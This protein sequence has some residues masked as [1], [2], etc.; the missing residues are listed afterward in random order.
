MKSDYFFPLQPGKNLD[1]LKLSHATQQLLKEIIAVSNPPQTVERKPASIKKIKPAFKVLFHGAPGT[2]K[3]EVAALLG[4]EMNMP[5]YRIELSAI[6]SKYIG[7]TE[8]N[9]RPLFNAAAEANAI[10]LL[11][12]AEALFGKRSDVKDAHDRYAN[13]EV[14]YLMQQ[15]EAYNGIVILATNKKAN[16]DAAFLRK[17]RFIVAF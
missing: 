4:K 7:E 11:D 10:L 9:L 17:L 12:E 3:S 13:I 6:V 1:E 5:V 14:N 2:V 8:K 15:I 16:V